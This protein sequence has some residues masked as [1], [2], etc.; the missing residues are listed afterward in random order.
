MQ[1]FEEETLGR[2]GI[3]RWTQE[4]LQRVPLGI[5]RPVEVRPRSFDLD[6]GFVNAPGVIGG[7]EMRLRAL[8]QF[9]GIVLHESDRWWY[10]PPRV[11]VPASSLRGRGSSASSASTTARTA[12]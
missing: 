12:Q 7:F 9:G 5:D 10:D 6:V 8:L 1:G 4:K 3:A 2:L 11:P